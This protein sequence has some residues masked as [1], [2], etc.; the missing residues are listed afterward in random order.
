MR[1]AIV[2]LS[3]PEGGMLHYTSQLANALASFCDVHVFTPAKPELDGYFDDAV[4]LHPTVPLS[5]RSARSRSWLAQINP[6][7]HHENARRI[8]SI[9]PDVVHF[10]TAHPSNACLL[11]LLGPAKSCFTLHDPTR[12]PGERSFLK[13]L[14]D[15]AAVAL[16]SRIVVHGEALRAEL[17]ARHVPLARIDVIAH[18]D[19]GFLKR[20][21]PT[22]AEEPLILCFGRMVEYKGL[23]VLCRAE[24][25][26]ASRLG[27]YQV[28]IAGEGD[29]DLFQS[30]IGPSRRVTVINRFL[31]DTEVATLFQRARLVVLPYTQASQSGVLA[32]AFAFGKPAIVTS[33][34]ALPE[35]VG[36]G[37]AGMIVA[38]GDDRA[39]A[40]AIELLW[41]RPDLR[42]HYAL[43]G[44]RLVEHEIGWHHVA[45]RYL[46]TYHAARATRTIPDLKRAT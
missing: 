33:V 45:R 27:G 28:C 25:H 36:F 6:L 7:H 23:D 3:C 11:A 17:L 35:A 20:L 19:Y 1:V 5:F 2:A 30:A 8:R 18:G 40:E 32:I 14:L 41:S 43:A 26:L 37:Q 22:V 31:S 46:A 15:R 39:L 34:G 13:D 10:T 4:H 38:P 24:Q 44:Q 12:H 21:A 42:R 29:P 16:T 9:R